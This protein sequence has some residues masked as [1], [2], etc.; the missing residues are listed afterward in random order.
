MTYKF[1]T[2]LVNLLVDPRELLGHGAGNASDATIILSGKIPKP[3]AVGLES[4]QMRHQVSKE[5]DRA[6]C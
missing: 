6:R 1:G 5:Q 2:K 4:L 3:I